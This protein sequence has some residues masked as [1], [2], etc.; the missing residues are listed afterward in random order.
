MQAPSTPNNLY[1]TDMKVQKP[2]KD[3]AP[4]VLDSLTIS[5]KGWYRFKFK[6]AENMILERTYKS[7]PTV[8]SGRIWQRKRWSK[9]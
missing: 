2:P 4:Q 6:M 7:Y 9:D 8:P 3:E 5:T 1:Q